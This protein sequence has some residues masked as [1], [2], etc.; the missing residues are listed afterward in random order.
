MVSLKPYFLSVYINMTKIKLLS[1]WKQ[2]LDYLNS[3]KELTRDQIKMKAVMEFE[4]QKL[5]ED[6]DKNK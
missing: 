2:N 4:I 5:E 3:L 1:N 6:L